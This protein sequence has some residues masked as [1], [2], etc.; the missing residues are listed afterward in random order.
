MEE[1]AK[2]EL[3]P[4]LQLVRAKNEFATHRNIKTYDLNERSANGNAF[5]IENGNEKIAVLV[6]KESGL[7]AEELKRFLSIIRYKISSVIPN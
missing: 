7:D 5:I 1:F 6:L 3:T 2:N 4:N